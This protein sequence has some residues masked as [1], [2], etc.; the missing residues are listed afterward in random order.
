MDRGVYRS[1]AHRSTPEQKAL[2]ACLACGAGAVLSHRAAAAIWGAPGMTL[3]R[4]H[5]TVPWDRRVSTS[6]AAVHRSTA[7]GR[8]DVTTFRGMPLTTPA[9]TLID[10]A[11]MVDQELAED[12]VD[13]FLCRGYLSLGHLVRRATALSASGREGPAQLLELLSAWAEDESRSTQREMRVLRFV[14]AAGLPLPQRQFEV[15]VGGRLIARVDDAYPERLI[16]LEFNSFR[17]H[18]VRRGFWNDQQRVA[19][20]VA[21]GW[22]VYPITERD[23]RA[24]C[25]PLCR[26]LRTELNV[27]A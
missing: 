13:E 5:V 19:Q 23:I 17:W 18:A 2:A 24:K 3:S 22:R 27:A 15:R 10:I 16:A 4:V 21:L 20:L 11:A 12:A 25:A 7:L 1:T 6:L 9:R 26:W 8:L 14:E